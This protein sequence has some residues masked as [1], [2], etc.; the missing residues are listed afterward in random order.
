MS[1]W[2]IY[3]LVQIFFFGRLPVFIFL[4]FFPHRSTMVANIFTQPLTIKKLHTALKPELG[5]FLTHIYI[6]RTDR[7][8]LT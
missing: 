3:N 4:V 1:F 5:L 8:S 6:V 7:I 2:I